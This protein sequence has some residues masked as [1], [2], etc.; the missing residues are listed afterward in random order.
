[1]IDAYDAYLALPNVKPAT[2][3]S[4]GTAAGEVAH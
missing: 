2:W 3:I 1:L 4:S